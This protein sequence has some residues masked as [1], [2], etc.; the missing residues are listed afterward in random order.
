MCLCPI[1]ILNNSL[2]FTVGRD[3]D[4]FYVPCGKCYECRNA[5]RNDYV[6]RLI[7]EKL[8]TNS[9]VYYYTLTFNNEHLPKIEIPDLQDDSIVTTYDCFDK[10]LVQKFL[11]RLRRY[12]WKF[13]QCR[14]RYFITSEFGE[15]F[16]RPH[17]H[18]L[19]YLNKNV[20]PYDFRKIITLL[21]SEPAKVKYEKFPPLSFFKNS[22]DVLNYVGSRSYGF[23]KQGDNEGLVTDYRPLQYVA[24][25]VSKDLA[26]ESYFP[27]LRPYKDVVIR[28]NDVVTF[29]YEIVKDCLPFTLM[30]NNFGVKILDQF[31]FDNL[32]N[33]T[34]DVVNTVDG[35]KVVS[36]YKIPNYFLKKILYIHGLNE[37]GNM[38]YMLNKLGY[39]VRKAQLDK[40]I[41][42]VGS[43]IQD[44][45]N[46]I[47]YHGVNI[48][49]PYSLDDLEFMFTNM[50]SDEKK[51][52]GEYKYFYRNKL[53]IDFELDFDN[54][55]NLFKFIQTKYRKCDY[56]YKKVDVY[57]SSLDV[58]VLEEICKIMDYIKKQIKFDN[59]NEK[60]RN[61]I[62]FKQ[63][64]YG[65]KY[66]AES[67][68]KV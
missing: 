12:L 44:C 55:F 8:T 19:F 9:T 61:E 7:A 46:Y 2:D 25:Y 68:E 4:F 15:K 50:D 49:L 6:F 58:V 34:Y 52:I 1:K 24:K 45:V 53:H 27:D 31:T 67:K 42:N 18:C 43:E 36:T 48:R 3:A 29:N 62:I 20:N 26:F 21:W 57:S 65:K 14:F 28:I 56:L 17:H 60:S 63:F 35:S 37:N 41:K 30:S 33:S 32:V 22:D 38:H 13:Y 39:D 16:H 47:R 51:L 54:D 64:Y 59:A 66:I 23:N 5:K 11:K 10:K 40:Q